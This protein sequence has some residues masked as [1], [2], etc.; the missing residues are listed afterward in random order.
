MDLICS[1]GSTKLAFLIPTYSAV[2]GVK[3]CENA[4]YLR[5]GEEAKRGFESEVCI[6]LVALL[7]YA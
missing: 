4:M 6:W 1:I 2:A 7:M 3:N 5:N